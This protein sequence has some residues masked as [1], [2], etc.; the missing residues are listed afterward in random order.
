MEISIVSVATKKYLYYWIQMLESFCKFNKDLTNFEFILLTDKP[1]EAERN[2]PEFMHGKVK[3]IEIPSYGWPDATL[4]RYEL[5]KTNAPLFEKKILMYLD[6][7]MLFQSS[8]SQ[9]LEKFTPIDQI[10]LIRHPGYYRPRGKRLWSLY[11]ESPKLLLSDLRLRI[12]NGGIGAWEVR[13][14]SKAFVPK[15]HRQNYFCGGTWFGPRK[16]VIEMCEELAKNVYQDREMGIEAIWHDESH[17]NA[18]ASINNHGILDP[19]LCF[20]SRCKSLADLT[21]V[22]IAVDKN[23]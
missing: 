19:S 7:D 22:I 16:K 4:L 5:I 1:N 3:C 17:L 9:Y 23:G 14:I 12:K 20:D 15:R 6:A 13:E 2:I 10:M 8:L 18:W 11:F 21:P